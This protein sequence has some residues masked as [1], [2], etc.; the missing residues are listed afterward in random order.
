MT[1]EEQGEQAGAGAGSDP[2]QP[3]RAWRFAHASVVGSSHVKNGTP[4]Q[5]A[6]ACS[7]VEQAGAACLVAVVSDGAGSAPLSQIGSRTACE[8]VLEETRAAL[9]YGA[10][11][12]A[13]DRGFALGVI[14]RLRVRIARVARHADRPV[15][16]FACTLLFAVADAH[17]AVFAQIGDGAIVVAPSASSSSSAALAEDARASDG[18][19]WVFWPE[20]GEYLNQTCFATEARAH[21][22]LQYE[23]WNLP[24]DELAL[25]SDGLQGL[26]LDSRKRRAHARFFEPMFVAVRWAGPGRS[27]ALGRALEGFLGSRA[28]SSRTDDDK[29]L[30]L[31][32][33]RA[34]EPRPV[35][36]APLASPRVAVTAV[37]PREL[38][39]GR[40]P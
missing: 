1:T 21:E 36:P 23:S 26:V 6:S 7:L 40:A 5:D 27:E 38:R 18:Y 22:H 9:A 20:Q 32:S 4:C 37:L 31:A 12:E 3:V 19:A 16:D 13:L 30:V 34:P 8:V 14:E 33:R 2:G 11:L 25:F 28:I 39:E 35:R 24:I 29:S 17:G 15:R 10:G